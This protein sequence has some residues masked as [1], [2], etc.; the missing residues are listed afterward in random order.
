MVYVCLAPSTPSTPL[1][2]Q[3]TVFERVRTIAGYTQPHMHALT[4]AN[5]LCPV[6]VRVISIAGP[7]LKHVWFSGKNTKNNRRTVVAF[8]FAAHSVCLPVCVCVSVLALNSAFATHACTSAHTPIN[9]HS[10]ANPSPGQNRQRDCAEIDQTGSVDVAV[11]L[12]SVPT[13]AAMID[14]WRPAI[15]PVSR[16]RVGFN[17]FRCP[18]CVLRDTDA[19]R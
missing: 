8:K 15:R 9:M 10:V 14:R 11:F 6:R 18:T 12:F 7:P 3:Y 4:H 13:T 1:P 19:T 5:A 17:R 2:P 16:A